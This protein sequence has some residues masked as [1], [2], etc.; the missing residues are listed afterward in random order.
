ML[1]KAQRIYYRQVAY[2][3]FATLVLG[4][5]AFIFIPPITGLSLEDY[6]LARV[7]DPA[8]PIEAP[9][10]WEYS[11]R[12]LFMVGVLLPVVVTPAVISNLFIDIFI[13]PRD[14]LVR[15]TLQML[16]IASLVCGVVSVGFFHYNVLYSQTLGDRMMFMR[17]QLIWLTTHYF[18]IL[19]VT[20]LL[21]MYLAWVLVNARWLIGTVSVISLFAAVITI[22]SAD[23]QVS[24]IWRVIVLPMC[25]AV[26]ASLLAVYLLIESAKLPPSF[27]TEF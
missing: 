13:S 15:H 20:G 19:V 4:A 27:S 6:N 17:W 24:P 2:A 23:P 14:L 11:L 16:L 5:F 18:L 10:G 26:N 8:Q 3:N 25:L 12:F 22:W 21:V 9:Q 1:T 7:Y